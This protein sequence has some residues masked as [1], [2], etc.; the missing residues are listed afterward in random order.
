M[1]TRRVRKSVEGFLKVCE[2]V[3]GFSHL[4]F[5]MHK[6]PSFFKRHEKNFNAKKSGDDLESSF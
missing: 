3:K 5:K 4:C 1:V 6:V 2:Y